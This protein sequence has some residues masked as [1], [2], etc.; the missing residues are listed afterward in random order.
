MGGWFRAAGLAVFCV[1]W[2]FVGAF[3]AVWLLGEDLQGVPGPPGPAGAAG[4]Q[5]PTGDT[6]DT[7]DLARRVSELEGRVGGAEIGDFSGS[8]FGD[9]DLEDRVSELEREMSS[10]CFTL[11]QAGAPQP[12]AC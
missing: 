2:G 4:P 6:A 12:F 10:V 8:S 9:D 5:G 11:T 3:A 7:A 1:V